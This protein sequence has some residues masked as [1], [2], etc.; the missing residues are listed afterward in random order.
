[1]GRVKTNK[2]TAVERVKK[3]FKKELQDLIKQKLDEIN[4]YVAGCDSPFTYLQIAGVQENLRNIM[5]E[6][7][8]KGGDGE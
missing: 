2:E 8:I 6:L 5:E 1:M 7:G 4:H 3:A